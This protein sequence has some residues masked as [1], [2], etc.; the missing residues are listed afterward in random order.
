MR[1]L[2]LLLL[3]LN[4]AFFAWFWQ[5]PQPVASQTPPQVAEGGIV[6]L[7]E[8]PPDA[9][10]ASAE[11]LPSLCYRAGPFADAAQAAQF[12]AALSPVPVSH[13]RR[14]EEARVHAG[15][16]VRWPARVGLGEARRLYKMLQ[17]QGVEDLAITPAG[18]GRYVIS[19]G[20]FRHRET[21]EERRQELA[22]LD[23]QVEVEDRYRVR[24]QDW[25]YLVFRERQAAVTAALEAAAGAAGG[26][27]FTA[28]ECP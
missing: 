23:H 16:W 19:L 17:A 15:Y 24:S 4:V 8:R 18:E 13:Q 27:A 14:T 20:V 28:R 9:G 6:L 11:P 5:R 3:L 22:A 2:F 21:M 25:L 26:V 1:V 12:L 7:S 10:P